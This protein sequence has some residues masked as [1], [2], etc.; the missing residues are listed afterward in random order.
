MAEQT[1]VEKAEAEKE[2]KLKMPWYFMPGPRHPLNEPNPRKQDHGDG[3][4]IQ[5]EKKPQGALEFSD[6]R[7]KCT[8]N[9]A[10]RDV[11]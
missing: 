6:P 10:P 11:R 4:W 2:R 7:V 1:D 5:S 8:E 9:Y 3:E